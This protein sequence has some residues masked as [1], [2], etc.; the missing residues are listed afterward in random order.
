MILLLY[1]YLY[2]ADNADLC[3]LVLYLS[4]IVG[5]YRSIEVIP[6]VLDFFLLA[7]IP[8]KND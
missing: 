7:L 5:S 4:V 2:R 3:L 8:Y 1:W 6:M